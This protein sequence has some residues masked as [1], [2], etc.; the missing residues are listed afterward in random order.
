[1]ERKILTVIYIPLLIEI[2]NEEDEEQEQKQEEEE[3]DNV[4][5]N[6]ASPKS[7]QIDRVEVSPLPRR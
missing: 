5:S 7:A 1:M 2:N 6:D 4:I 3:A